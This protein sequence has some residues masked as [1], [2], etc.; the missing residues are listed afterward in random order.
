MLLYALGIL[1]MLVGLAVSIGLHEVG[2]LVPAK[3]FGV[4]V[5]QFM[6]GFG[7]TL[8]S[9]R[10]GET[11]Y[12]VKLIPLGGYVAMSG[13]YPPAKP[14][15]KPRDASTGFLDNVV[16]EARDASADTI[17]EGQEN[18]TFYLLPMWKKIV[19]MLGGPFMN[20]VLACVFF[21]IV[22]MG[23]GVAQYSTTLGQVSQCLIPAS[24]EQTQCT[25]A[26][27][28]SPA[29]EAGMLPGDRIVELG[30][31]EITEWQQIGEVVSAAPGTTMLAQIER[32][33]ELLG[34]TL[35]PA[36][37][38]RWVFDEQGAVVEDAN[39]DPVTE[40]VGMIGV[41]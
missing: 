19:I 22:L 6:V 29:A 40:V 36:A 11:E 18:R 41:T 38:E 25:D 2:H 33:G 15:E 39:G 27:P 21:G 23:F 5:S 35:V 30:G 34:L 1:I 26:D 31:V 8:W 13:M 12:G 3:L 16:Q 17:A 9:K 24:S 4:R 37:T 20:L 14:G 32:D 7:K 10:K 28:L